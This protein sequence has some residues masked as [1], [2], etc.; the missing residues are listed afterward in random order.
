[1]RGKKTKLTPEGPLS[2][3]AMRFSF[4]DMVVYMSVYLWKN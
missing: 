4:V 3:A 1:M 2:S